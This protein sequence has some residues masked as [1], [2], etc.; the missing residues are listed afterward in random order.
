MACTAVLMI[1]AVSWSLFA[2][3]A[4]AAAAAKITLGLSPTSIVADGVSTSKATA[5]VTDA[6]GRRLTGEPVKFNAP[7]DKV[8]ATT[9]GLR[10]TYTATITST[11]PG[12]SAVTAS[13]GPLT[14][15]GKTLTRTPDPAATVAL[16]LSKGSIVAD[17]VDATTAIATVTDSHNNPVTAATVTFSAPGDAVSGTTNHGD[18]TYTAAITSTTT[19][20]S[21]VTAS[22]GVLTSPGATLTRLV[23]QPGLAT[24]TTS[25]GATPTRA[26]TNQPV[27]L[28][29][30]VTSSLGALPPSGTI[31]FENGGHPVP[32]CPN[33]T[34][35]STAQ[36]ATVLCQ[37]SFAASTAGLTAIFTP[38]VGSGLAGSASPVASVTIGKGSTS[39]FLTVPN[40]VTAGAKTT[41]RATVV[42]GDA[43]PVEPSGS[44]QFLD[45]GKPVASCLS[46]PLLKGTGSSSATCAVSYSKISSHSISV[47][48]GGDANFNGSGSS[49]QSVQFRTHSTVI[50][51]TITATMQWTFVHTPAYT[52]ILALLLN[53]ARV[54]STVTVGCR[55]RGCPS[56]KMARVITKAKPCKRKG[57][58]RC[59]KPP[60]PGRMNLMPRFSGHRLHPGAKITVEI[61]QRGWV[62]KYYTFTIRARRAPAINIGCIAPGGTRLG[63]GC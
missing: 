39:A 3:R 28:F 61:T 41:F 60:P 4:E 63:V 50:L 15:A 13:D 32:G 23:P 11:T 35:T 46:Q 55:G 49:A 40:P 45:N 44:V 33:Q 6:S 21:A 7:G 62:G 54:G 53:G 56:G 57:K 27:T 22:A 38:S 52:K 25:L 48:Y 51:G 19:G 24:T 58:H 16:V 12:Q 17:G 1:T 18:G 20:Q 31:A 42:P 2:G 36:S 9:G 26:G 37:T 43:G 8:S 5:T 14:S 47:R 10:G 59:P 30:T 34:I 29:A